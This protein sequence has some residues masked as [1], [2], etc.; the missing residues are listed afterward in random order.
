[1][2]QE[3][4]NRVLNEKQ[5]KRVL[6]FLIFVEE[7]E[8]LRDWAKVELRKTEARIQAKYSSKEDLYMETMQLIARLANLDS[9]IDATSKDY[10][11]FWELYK[12]ELIS[13]ESLEVE[14]L[15]VS[16]GQELKSLSRSSAPPSK[17]LKKLS[18]EIALR[19]KKE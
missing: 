13:V 16:I 2:R 5:S 10:E 14:G 15:M 12:G 9:A 1:M 3:Y 11:R 18:F 7:D 4:L 19:M 17:T 8:R 6:E